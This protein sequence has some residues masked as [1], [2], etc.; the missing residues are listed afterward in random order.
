MDCT[1]SFEKQGHFVENYISKELQ[2]KDLDR[3]REIMRKPDATESEIRRYHLERDMHRYEKIKRAA[4]KRQVQIFNATRGG[5][6]EVFPRKSLNELY[7][8]ST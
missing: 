6:L 7:K 5:Q 3:T 1:S 8:N 2:N 4:Q